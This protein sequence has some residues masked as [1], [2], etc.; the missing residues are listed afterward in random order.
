M[1][2]KRPFRRVLWVGAAAL[3]L[4]A[5]SSSSK[6]SSSSPTTAAAGSQQST[7]STSQSSTGSAGSTG[8]AATAT[9][10]P[11]VIGG[12]CDCSGPFGNIANDFEAYRAWV[13]SVNDSGGINGHPIKFTYLNDQSNPGLAITDVH[14]L[15]ETDHAIAIVDASNDDVGFQ[16]YLQSKG[17]PVVGSGNSSDPFFTNPDFYPEGQ[18]MDAVIYSQVAIAKG[19]GAKN[20]GVMYCAEAPTCAA[21]VGPFKQAGQQLGLTV[22]V[23]L[24][25]PATSPNYTAACIA[26]QQ[27][28]TEALSVL[29]AFAAV[30]H[31]VSDC[32]KQGYH[33]VWVADGLDLAPS[34]ATTPGGLYL[35]VT[36]IPYFVNTPAIQKMNAAFDKYFPGLRTS[37]LFN[38]GTASMWDSGLLFAAAAKAGGLGANG[39]APTS[40]QLVK[41]L[42][43]L[44]NETL[45]GTAPPLTFKA[46]QP[47]PVDCWF[48]A[49]MKDGKAS[50]PIGTQTVCMK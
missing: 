3:V 29:Q 12:I 16:S 35:N 39:S 11:I 40:A 23:S 28:H 46:G 5:C 4:A 47:H 33:P 1:T 18:T 24:K 9:G 19:A 30:D 26:S 27:A 44:T 8:S 49:L 32:T 43:S 42:N 50:L 34:F 22:P 7:G 13:S 41:G 45:D 37:P 15:V 38:E 25:I 14:T 20:I 21:A 36:N 10:S 2:N 31:V 6:T 48:E 17:V